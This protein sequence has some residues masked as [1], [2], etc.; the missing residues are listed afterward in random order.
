MKLTRGVTRIVLLIGP[1]AIKVPRPHRCA[2]PCYPSCL[3][4]GLHANRTEAKR[5]AERSEHEAA[6]MAPV[7]A[8]GAW[9]LV[10]KRCE[11][12]AHGDVDTASTFW[13]GIINPHDR[14]P[15]NF[16]RLDGRPVAIDYAY[17]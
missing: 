17:W 15:H 9:A 11:P 7:I 2:T 14:A 8:G 6:A 5:W 4:A 3:R 12:V 16:G 10:M 13:D 1:Y